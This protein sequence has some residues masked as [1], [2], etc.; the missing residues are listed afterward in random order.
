VRH[1]ACLR[2]VLDRRNKPVVTHSLGRST[3]ANTRL[4][5]WL[6]WIPA[7]QA[8]SALVLLLAPVY[9]VRT[10]DA[11]RERVWAAWRVSRAPAG[12]TAVQPRRLVE[13]LEDRA[14]TTRAGCRREHA[15][16]PPASRSVAHRF[17]RIGRE[18]ARPRRRA[19]LVERI[20][21][22]FRARVPTLANAVTI[23]A[24]N[25]PNRSRCG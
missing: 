17:E 7:L 25:P 24:W 22:Y 2:P 13:L 3:S 19:E 9:I 11:E 4:V 21:T 8:A 1:A 23:T 14:E 5:R 20:A 15:R 18:R 6:R 10:R 16:R 12:N